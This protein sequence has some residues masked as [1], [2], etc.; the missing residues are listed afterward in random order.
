MSSPIERSQVGFIQSALWGAARGSAV[1]IV[2]YP[3]E[4]IKIE[5]QCS[6]PHQ[7]ASVIG[8]KIF[9]QEGR[10]GLYRGLQ[11]QLIKTCIKQFLCWPI[12]T[13]LPRYLKPYGIGELQQQIVTGLSVATLDSILTSPLERLKTLSARN[14][15]RFPLR[16]IFTEGW[17]GLWPYWSKRAINMCTFLTA[18]NYLR[19]RARSNSDQPL[20]PFQTA[21]V[22]TQTAFIVSLVSGPSD[23]KN[24]LAQANMERPT[25]PWTAKR[26]KHSFCG[27]RLNIISFV[28]QSIAS[29]YVFEQVEQ[30]R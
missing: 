3:L 2:L 20:T 27:W 1:E 10:A 22:G 30:S 12:M 4:R 7:K 21:L 6:Q 28:I 23:V 26:I 29:V 17:V 24:T 19:E 15:K 14:M 25:G 5:Q 13:H 8:K 11:P 18:Q 9:Q 16:E